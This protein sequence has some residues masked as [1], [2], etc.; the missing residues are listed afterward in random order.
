MN[1]AKLALLVKARN[2]A[3]TYDKVPDAKDY[4]P[5]Q[6]EAYLEDPKDRTALVLMQDTCACRDETSIEGDIL[7]E[8]STLPC[9][10]CDKFLVEGSKTPCANGPKAVCDKDPRQW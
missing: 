9:F 5:E 1:F 10:T 3:V 4:D 6:I 7:D 2:F 8:L